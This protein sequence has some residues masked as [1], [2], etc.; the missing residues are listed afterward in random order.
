MG[1]VAQLQAGRHVVQHVLDGA[2]AVAQLPGD[3]VG[4]VAV[5]DQ[6]QNLDL[7]FRQP[8]EGQAAR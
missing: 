4:V 8:G 5:G 2:L 1:P 7:A 3:L 6:P